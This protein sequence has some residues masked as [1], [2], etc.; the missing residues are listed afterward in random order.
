MC[1]LQVCVAGCGLIWLVAE[2]VGL[3][4]LC[5]VFSLIVVVLNGFDCL[6]ACVLLVRGFSD[7][8]VCG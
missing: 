3:L 4:C 8:G 7:Y 6:F 5:Y 1:R 2:A